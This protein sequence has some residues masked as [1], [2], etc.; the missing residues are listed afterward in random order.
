MSTDS[1]RRLI[2][3]HVGALTRGDVDAVVRI[4]DDDF[5]Q[6]WPQSGE[7]LRGKQACTIVY[8]NYPGGPPTGMLRRLVGSGD[9]WIAEV[10]MD[11]AGKPVH[12]VFIFELRDGRLVRETD[13]FADPFAA[14]EWRVQWVERMEP[15]PQ[16]ATP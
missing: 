2:E 11:Y 6:E 13:Y 10:T 16:A 5:V 8:R 3:E 9:L 4:I 1:N 12:G 15:A 14:P 7:R